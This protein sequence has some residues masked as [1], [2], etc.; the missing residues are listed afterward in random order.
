MLNEKKSVP[1]MMKDKEDPGTDNEVT[2]VETTSM[3][4]DTNQKN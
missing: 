4:I 2:E 1:I 3:E